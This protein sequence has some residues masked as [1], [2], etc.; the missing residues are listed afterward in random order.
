MH[1]V[2]NEHVMKINIKNSNENFD[3][4][5]DLRCANYSHVQPMR[6]AFEVVD[7]VVTEIHDSKKN[8]FEFY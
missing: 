2:A 1:F 3:V 5:A 7:F 4:G 8:P 6:K